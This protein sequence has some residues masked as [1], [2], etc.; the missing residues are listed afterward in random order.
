MNIRKELKLTNSGITDIIDEIRNDAVKNGFDK[1]EVTRIML[2]LEEILIKFQNRFGED[3][4]MVLE[5][6]LHSHKFG[7]KVKILSNSFNPFEMGAEEY[8]DILQSLLSGQGLAFQWSYRYGTNTL[9]YSF[10]KKRNHSTVIQL[11]ASILASIICATIC[12]FLPDNIK[13]FVTGNLI[14][15]L[16]DTFIG[17]ISFVSSPLV[18]L[19][20]MWG[21][22]SIGDVTSLSN[23]GKRMIKRFLLLMA[24]S[25]GI[26]LLVVLPFYELSPS[27]GKTYSF[28]NLYNMVLDIIPDNIISP[29][30]NS[31]TLQIIFI[32]IIIGI[33]MLLLS[34]KTTVA[35]KFVEQTNYIIQLIMETVSKFISIFVFLSLFQLIMSSGFHL[36]LGSY[37]LFITIILASA[38]V[39]ILQGIYVC[40]HFKLSP[41]TLI[42]KLSSTF[43]IAITTASSSA[44]FVDDMETC[45][46]KLGIDKRII[47]IGVPLG[48]TIYMPGSMIIFYCLTLYISRFFGTEFSIP[49]LLILAFLSV[50]LAVAAPPVPG[51]GLACYALII[52]QMRLPPEAVATFVAL[53]VIPDF[54]CTATN[55]SSL[56]MELLSLADSLNMLD[57]EK[58]KK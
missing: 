31:N 50:I 41:K 55:I 4:D 16:Y 35:A 2:T 5:G 28:M 36:L 1:K 20:V 9:S 12:G 37:K 43:I 53:G 8:N 17:L 6:N 54:I 51:G 33:A 19:T 27:D 30:L 34:E 38:V 45:E 57:R 56:Q 18:L 24:T 49:W 11:F 40:F 13:T 52:S 42:K 48:Q 21:V 15:P 26:T 25:A 3:T 7:I 32:A 47:N 46:K 58:L 23:I 22:Y 39:L 29:F 14:S 44:S 10:K